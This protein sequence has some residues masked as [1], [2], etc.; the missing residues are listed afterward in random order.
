MK[1]QVIAAAAMAVLLL[2]AGGCSGQT[3]PTQQTQD[4]QSTQQT[5][6]TQQTQDTQPPRN[7]E[8]TTMTG[9]WESISQEDAAQRMTMREDL[10][11]VDVRQPYE[12][13]AGH[14][15]GAICVP[16]EDI[17]TE[18]PAALPDLDQVLLVYCRS[19]RRSKEAAEKLAQIGYTNI[20]EFGGIL[21]W[22]GETVAGE[23]PGTR[24][25]GPADP[26]TTTESGKTGCAAVLTVSSFDGG[27][28]EFEFITDEPSV[29]SWDVT[30]EYGRADHD[31]I[32]GAAYDVTVTLHA[33]KE[34]SAT[35]TVLARSPIADNYDAAYY[36]TVDGALN[37][38]VSEPVI[39]EVS[40]GTRATD[41]VIRPT[42]EL[43]IEV[44]GRTFYA[45]PEDNPSAEEFIEKLSREGAI[46]VA[47]RDYGNFEKVGPLPWTL[48][49]SDEDI[50]TVPGDVILYQ[51][52][53]I[54]IYYDTNQW[55][56]TRLARI[57]NATGEELLEAFGSGDV[58]VT[59]WVEWSE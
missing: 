7:T 44:N 8:E 35:F 21:D 22:T 56:F 6:E 2:L 53:Q 24:P 1:R 19:G 20:Y 26:A 27:G 51:G 46:E 38:T 16:N 40:G 12:Y 5:Q 52:N 36:V 14:I 13:E 50:T 37:I 57:G 33:L 42:P 10:L 28:P 18:M 47:M 48:T 29:I 17:G 39:Y 9:H 55:N 30:R 15:P 41:E 23:E 49:R 43:V 58:T 4:T 25:V 32:D 3:Q 45:H 54:T 11:I 59:F 34:G 31:Q